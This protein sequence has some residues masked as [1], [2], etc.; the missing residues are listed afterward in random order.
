MWV[1]F[2]ANSECYQHACENTAV[3]A[4][5]ECGATSGDGSI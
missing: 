5:Q 3:V 4:K 2:V 1:F